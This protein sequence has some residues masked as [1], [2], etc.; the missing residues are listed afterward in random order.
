MLSVT[1][2]N[3][4]REALRKATENDMALETHVALIIPLA[5]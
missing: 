2:E 4:V 3:P 5:G 1:N